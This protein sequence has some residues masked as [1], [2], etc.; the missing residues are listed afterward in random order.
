MEEECMCLCL[1]MIAWDWVTYQ[2]LVPTEDS[3]SFS[4]QPLIAK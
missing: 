1:G 4:Q 2:E 3:F